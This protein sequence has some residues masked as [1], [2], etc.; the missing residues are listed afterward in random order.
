MSSIHPSL[1]VFCTTALFLLMLTHTHT[2]TDSPIHPPTLMQS[3]ENHWCD[4]E[5]IRMEELSGLECGVIT[6]GVI[7]SMFGLL[8]PALNKCL[9]SKTGL[10]KEE[11]D[12]ATSS[13]TLY[14]TPS[15]VDLYLSDLR[16]YME[17]CMAAEK[18]GLTIKFM[19]TDN[20]AFFKAFV[21]SG[22]AE[23]VLC[24]KVKPILGIKKAVHVKLAGEVIPGLLV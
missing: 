6:E 10:T 15:H 1:N 9:T 13:L 8:G 3:K 2:H 16:L 12:M 24:N 18:S 4:V 21:K 20:H 5:S 17:A 14:N 23:K 22:L 11:A 19:I 7:R